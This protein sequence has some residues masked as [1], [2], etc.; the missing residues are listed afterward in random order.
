MDS[1]VHFHPCNIIFESTCNVPLSPNP[2]P[3][4][5]INFVEPIVKLQPKTKPKKHLHPPTKI[6]KAKH[7]WWLILIIT[8]TI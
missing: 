5:S 8:K 4:S 2:I 6:Y 7:I 1:V 3:N